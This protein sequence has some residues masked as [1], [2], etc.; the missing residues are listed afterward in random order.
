MGICESTNNDKKEKN[1]NKEEPKLLSI[2]SSLIS[3][4]KTNTPIKKNYFHL[5]LKQIINH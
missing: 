3:D 2:E 1:E 5:K 4:Y